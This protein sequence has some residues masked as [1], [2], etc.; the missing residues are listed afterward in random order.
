MPPEARQLRVKMMSDHVMTRD[1]IVAHV[2]EMFGKLDTNHDGYI[3]RDEA[4][5]FQS[6]MQG[7][8]EKMMG[9]HERMKKIRFNIEDRTDGEVPKMDRGAMF[10]RLDTNHDGVISRQEF[11]TG[12]ADVRENRMIVLRDGDHMQDMQPM[13]AIPKM[14]GDRGMMHMH[15]MGEGM[16]GMGAHL[17]EMADA[18]HDGRVSLQE[19][20][21]AV[22]AHFDRGDLN[23]DGRI[24]PDERQQV[25]QIRIQRQPS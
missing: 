14:P 5:A 1:E 22:L 6:K 4:D 21:A 19:A 12:R 15:G 10:D 17:F 13:H 16:G 23:H 24:T 9:M 7:M 2:R 20:E 3:T 11:L 25:R 18:N 8:H